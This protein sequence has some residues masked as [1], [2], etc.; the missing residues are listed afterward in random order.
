MRR[1]RSR[2]YRHGKALQDHTCECCSGSSAPDWLISSLAEAVA[3]DRHS[4]SQNFFVRMSSGLRHWRR[5]LRSSA[6]ADRICR[7]RLCLHGAPMYSYR[8]GKGRYKAATPPD[9]LR[10][11]TGGLERKRLQAECRLPAIACNWHALNCLKA[12]CRR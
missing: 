12:F 1:C 4:I 6:I 3:A 7:R 8:K 5:L 11:R 9:T 2:L 10:G